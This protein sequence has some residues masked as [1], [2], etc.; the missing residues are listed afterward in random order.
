VLTC[1]QQQEGSWRVRQAAVRPCVYLDHWALD[2]VGSPNSVARRSRVL[3]G[4]LA[5]SAVVPCRLRFA[6]IL[7]LPS[8]IRALPWTTR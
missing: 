4:D 7:A 1:V 8:T 2:Q 3:S 5:I 6:A